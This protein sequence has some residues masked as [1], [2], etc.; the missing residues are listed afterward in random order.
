MASAAGGSGG[1]GG[2]RC[3]S[4]EKGTTPVG[5]W[6]KKP[7]AFHR[8]ALRYLEKECV[9]RGKEPPFDLEDLLRRYGSSPPNPVVLTPSSSSGAARNPSELISHQKA[10]TSASMVRG[11]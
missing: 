2:D 7:S 6:C 1:G 11:R 3:S 9:A 8:A 4:G 5:H 10:S